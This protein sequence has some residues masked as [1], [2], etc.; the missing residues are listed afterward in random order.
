MVVHDVHATRIAIATVGIP[1]PQVWKAF[2]AIF[3]KYPKV[4]AEFLGFRVD[5]CRANSAIDCTL[6]AVDCHPCSKILADEMALSAECWSTERR[7]VDRQFTNYV[8]V[9]VDQDSSF[10]MEVVRTRQSFSQSSCVLC[11][12]KGQSSCDSPLGFVV[13]HPSRMLP[14]HFV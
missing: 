6:I 4:T 11:F 13:W 1:S 2:V 3:E 9:D 8:T 10:A 5:L 14:S 12:C 7:S